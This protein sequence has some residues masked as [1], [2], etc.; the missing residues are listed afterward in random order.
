M[1]TITEALT[2]EAAEYALRLRD[3][4]FMIYVPAK[5]DRRPA[6]WFHYSRE[7]DGQTCYGTYHAATN[8]GF[9]PANHSMPITPSRLNGSSAHVGASWGDE[10]TLGLD[11]VAADSIRMAEIVARPDNWCPFNAVPTVEAVAAASRPNGAPQR[12]YQGAR[13][14]NGKPY[15][16]GTAYIEAAQ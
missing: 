14:P 4:G 2:D 9:N 12:F 16:I 6:T 7:V 1:R 15:G 11:D 8:S 13:L 5:P 3:A 10:L